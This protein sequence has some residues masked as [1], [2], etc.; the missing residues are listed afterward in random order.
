MQAPV[1]EPVRN[2]IIRHV[3]VERLEIVAV[4]HVFEIGANR[5]ITLHGH[6]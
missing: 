6:D 3:F 4:E 2:E 1:A 5:R